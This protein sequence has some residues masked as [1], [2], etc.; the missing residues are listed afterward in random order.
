MCALYE[1]VCFITNIEV[2]SHWKWK[3]TPSIA[4]VGRTKCSLVER[5]G[6]GEGTLKSQ[7]EYALL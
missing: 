3:V 5:P 1:R 4:L 2:L 6:Q 7:D